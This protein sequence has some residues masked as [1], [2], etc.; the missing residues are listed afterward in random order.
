MA[1][2]AAVQPLVELLANASFRFVIPVYQRPY[3]WDNEHCQ[4]LW[5]DVL[6]VGRRPGDTHFTGS[7]VWVQDGTAAASGVTPRLLIDGQQRLTTLT[8]LII[9]LADY[10]RS[11]PG[12]ALRF[13]CDEIL[14][15]NY[16]L[17]R[18]K[19]GED[20]YKLTLSRGDRDALISLIDNLDNPD[21]KIVGKASR[22]VEN[23]SWFRK[24][25]ESVEDV[26]VVWDG[27]QRLFVVSIS[28]DAGR[29][30]P[31]LIFESM[32]STGKDLSSA[33]LIRNFVLMGLPRKE[34]NDLYLNHWRV[35]EEN[36]GIDRYDKVFDEFVR[37]FL[38]VLLAPKPLTKRDVYP[39]FKRYVF[40]NGYDKVGRMVE[41]LRQMET[42]AR[43]YSN[44]TAGTE[45]EPALNAALAS[46]ASLK[47]TTANPLLLSMYA[48]YEDGAFGID[49]FAA[50]VK[51]IESYVFRRAVCEIPTNAL[52]KFFPSLISKL[53]DAGAEGDDYRETLEVLLLREE[54]TARCFPTDAE[55][56][57]AL[58]TRNMFSFH[59]CFDALSCL[60]NM[61]HAKDQLPIKQGKYTIEHIMPQN[62]LAHEEWRK[63]LG[64]HCKDVFPTLVNTLGN[65]TLTA[66]NS[67]LSDGTFEQK[68]RRVI[69]GY[70][71]EYLV[72]SKAL[73][74]ADHWDAKSIAARGAALAE[75]ALRRWPFPSSAAVVAAARDDEPVE[76]AAKSKKTRRMSLRE[77]VDA[78][79]I[80]IGSKLVPDSSTYQ[81]YSATVEKGPIIRLSNGESYRSPSTAAEHVITLVSGNKRT[82]NGWDFWCLVGDGRTI[83]EI[84]KEYEKRHGYSDARNSAAV[85]NPVSEPVPLP[86]SPPSA[87]TGS[88]TD[89]VSKPDKMATDK[90][91]PTDLRP[92]YPFQTR[93]GTASADIGPN[94]SQR[95]FW[96]EFHDYCADRPDF[97]KE[98]G[99]VPPSDPPK[100]GCVSFDAESSNYRFDV[101]ADTRGNSI[102][103]SVW[104]NNPEAFRL[105]YNHKIAIQSELRANNVE[106]LWGEIDGENKVGYLVAKK[107]VSFKK[108]DRK[109]MYRWI[110]AWLGKLHS[111]AQ[112]YRR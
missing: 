71:N 16:L 15:N 67:E 25:V 4:Q 90:S 63:A 30:N 39:L 105:F 87:A 49:V 101:I 64:P 76:R 92:V 80:L 62:A 93:D 24:C 104:F 48:S 7:I 10:S 81:R 103:V 94:H 28:L 69:G 13:S 74:D 6:S 68:K 58:Q 66:Y 108:D 99:K 5:D 37:N 109:K 83:G 46:L 110:A 38:T 98:F 79:V 89:P 112:K 52:N 9:A 2:N 111:A 84:R 35:I 44:I 75:D 107:P 97:R 50:M 19:S 70:D 40:D 102:G 59:L 57:K 11:H 86:V 18:F 34:Q 72:I 22:I 60:E 47:V 91:L 51:L 36:L 85:S 26:N 27:I 73:H 3:S 77:T 82:K 45:E 55:F 32:N 14:G 17:N 88:K 61:H 1:M 21:S 54:G 96:S 41:L 56:S 106:L 42:F 12:K 43:Y 78:G 20:R 23:Y 31:Q 33:D 100:D 29:D 53:D 65:L 8:L 95:A